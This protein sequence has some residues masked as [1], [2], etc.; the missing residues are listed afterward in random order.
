MSN[1]KEDYRKIIEVR[2]ANNSFNPVVTY[3]AKDN[4]VNYYVDLPVEQRD[5]YLN[6]YYDADKTWAKDNDAGYGLSAWLYC[7][8]QT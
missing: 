3:D 7:K 4:D 8:W 1:P 6:G 5:R 2:I